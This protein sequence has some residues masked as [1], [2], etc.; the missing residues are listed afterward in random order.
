MSFPFSVLL[1]TNQGLYSLTLTSLN[2]I[3]RDIFAHKQGVCIHQE[4][5]SFFS[6][7]ACFFIC[8][9]YLLVCFNKTELGNV[10]GVIIHLG[11]VPIFTC[12][13]WDHRYICLYLLRFRYLTYKLG[14]LIPTAYDVSIKSYHFIVILGMLV[15]TFF[16]FIFY[17]AKNFSNY[18]Y[19]YCF[20]WKDDV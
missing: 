5:F 20:L 9:A 3:E 15:L 7:F 16:Y 11:S 1:P 4:F 19:W 2:C 6:L 14:I 17:I 8:L 10:G 12:Y 13:M 18:E